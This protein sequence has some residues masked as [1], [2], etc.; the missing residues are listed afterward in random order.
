MQE[1]RTLTVGR[2]PLACLR[3]QHGSRVLP[4]GLQ[5]QA[6]VLLR[7]YGG[8]NTRCALRIVPEILPPGSRHPAELVTLWF[9]KPPA[10]AARQAECPQDSSMKWQTGVQDPTMRR[11]PTS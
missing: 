3:A 8:Y 11:C 1:S 6:D 5:A 9:G 7:G 10:V 2:Q 4:Q